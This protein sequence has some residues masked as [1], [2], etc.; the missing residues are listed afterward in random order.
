MTP[1]LRAACDKAIHVLTPDGKLLRAGRAALYIFAAIGYS[2]F[3]KI[4][5]I[6]PLLW[7]TELGYWLVANNRKFFSKFLFTKE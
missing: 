7:A 6:P 5:S 3:A 2:T 1:A 4:F